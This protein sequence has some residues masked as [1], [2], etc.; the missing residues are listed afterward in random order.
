MRLS[1][2]ILSIALS[3]AASNALASVFGFVDEHGVA[4]FATEKL[5]SRYKLFLQGGQFLAPE[6]AGTGSANPALLRH[7]A[8]HPNLRKFEPLLKLASDEFAVDSTLLKAIMAAESGFDPEAV[9]PKGA[10]GLMQVMPATASR[11]GLQ[12]D[13]KKTVEEKL[14]DPKTNIRVGARYLRD[15]VRMFPDQ[16]ELVIAAYNAGEGAVQQHNRRIPPYPE[17]R[18]YVQVVTQFLRL[19]QSDQPAQKSVGNVFTRSGQSGR[20]LYLTLPGR[21]D[22]PLSAAKVSD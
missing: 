9:S 18:N 16:P 4:H 17:T 22:L 11:Y 8:N 21:R 5:D 15:L 7:L 3:V 14:S 10:I 6:V 13:T 19:Y 12:S 2:L 20:R 1:D